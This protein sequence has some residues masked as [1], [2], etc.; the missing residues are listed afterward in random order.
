MIARLEKRSRSAGDFPGFLT[1]LAT[2]SRCPP[3]TLAGCFA[4]DGNGIH[5]AGLY[6]PAWT[7]QLCGAFAVDDF[8][9]AVERL[10]AHRVELPWGLEED[11]EKYGSRVSADEQRI[12]GWMPLSSV[13]PYPFIRCAEGIR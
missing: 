13:R 9:V 6:Q 4:E 8:N 10:R 3:I 11:V 12:S 1:S 5:H 2:G 7:C